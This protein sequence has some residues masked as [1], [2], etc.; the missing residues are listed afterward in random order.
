[1]AGGRGRPASVQEYRDWAVP[2]TQLR[3]SK[4]ASRK[5]DSGVS[6]V[7]HDTDC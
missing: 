4:M 3:T 5:L 1:M 7:L 6:I 2:V